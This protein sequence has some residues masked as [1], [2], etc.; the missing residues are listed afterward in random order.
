MV[1]KEALYG[2]GQAT[3]CQ[4]YGRAG[5]GRAGQSIPLTYIHASSSCFCP[6]S[7]H[8]VNY[9]LIYERLPTENLSLTLFFS[10]WRNVNSGPFLVTSFYIDGTFPRF[11]DVVFPGWKIEEVMFDT[12]Y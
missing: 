9:V 7:K 5:Q 8:A 12:E 3:R 10:L 11:V 4:K 2:E 6:F 1:R